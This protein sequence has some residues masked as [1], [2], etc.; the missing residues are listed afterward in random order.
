M[1]LGKPDYVWPR[2]RHREDPQ[3]RSLL[4]DRMA[5]LGVDPGVLVD[6]LK[7]SGIDP[8]ETQGILMSLAEMK[9]LTEPGLTLISGPQAVD[10]SGVARDLYRDHH[11][12]R[13][14]LR[15]GT[16]PSTL[17]KGGQAGE[18]DRS[19]KPDIKPPTGRKWFL[20]PNGHT[21]SVAGPLE[22]WVG[23]PRGEVGR[24]EE[25]SRQYFRTGRT[26]AVAVTEITDGPVPRV[27]RRMRRSWRSGPRTTSRPR[28]GS[29]GTWPPVTATG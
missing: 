25:E 23:S 11:A 27:S 6:R 18:V 7:Q 9:K 19:Q 10:L 22:G 5:R 29:P 28:P 8:V 15:R 2:L 4:I 16:A 12:S 20:G 24:K 17:G 1:I 26:L 14:P 13:R 3:L 21:F